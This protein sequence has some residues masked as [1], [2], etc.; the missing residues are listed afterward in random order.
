MTGDELLA[1]AHALS[2]ELR[3]VLARVDLKPRQYRAL[4]ALRHRAL[5]MGELAAELDIRAPSAVALVNRLA[6]LGLVVRNVDRDDARV[7]LVTLT[8][9]G[10]GLLD[11]ADRTLAEAFDDL[12]GSLAEGGPESL[13]GKLEGRR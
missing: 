2:G 9:A 12:A 7:S 5:R 11:D 4:E 10:R 13:L 8:P 1:L 6:K 3:D